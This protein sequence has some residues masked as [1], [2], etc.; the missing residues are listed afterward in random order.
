MGAVF[1]IDAGV[2][3]LDALAAGLLERASGEPL[4][5]ARMT[6]LL[7]TR[8]AARSL[9]EAFLRQGNGRPLLLPRLVPVGDVDAD[10][11]AI[12]ADEG[13]G[14]EAIDLPPAVPDLTRRLMLTQLVLGWG[15]TPAGAGPASAAQAAPLAAELARFVDEVA[16]EGCALANLDRLVPAQHAAHWQQV[17]K[18]LQ[19]VSDHWPKALAEIGC[20]D[21]ADRRNRVLDRQ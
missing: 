13:V 3:F 7:P 1:S 15:K 19:I 20:L 5:L 14:D 2:P 12:L 16:A 8:R 9:A 17:V 6:V 21:V 10:E 18:F 11:L 4:T